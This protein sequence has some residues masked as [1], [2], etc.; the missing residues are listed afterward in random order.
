MIFQRKKGNSLMSGI[1]GMKI[2]R[3]AQDTVPFW[4]VY[5]NGIFLVGE[6]EYTLI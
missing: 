1:T 4:E 6:E 5:E 3:T 2:P